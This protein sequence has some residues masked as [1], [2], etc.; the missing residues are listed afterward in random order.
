[1]RY[2]LRKS[3]RINGIL[4]AANTVFDDSVEQGAIYYIPE[5]VATD[6][7]RQGLV[8]EL[9]TAKTPQALLDWPLGKSYGH[10]K[11]RESSEA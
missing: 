7:L 11:V 10:G 1:M 6:L 5:G 4:W 2:R 9:D 8:D 3:T